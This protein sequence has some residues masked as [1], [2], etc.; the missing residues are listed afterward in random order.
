MVQSHHNFSSLVFVFAVLYKSLETL[1]KL[2][3]SIK[4]PL[5]EIR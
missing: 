1:W 5:K 4:F 3:V 2:C